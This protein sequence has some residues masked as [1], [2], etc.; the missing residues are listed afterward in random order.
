MEQLIAELV[1]R[2]PSLMAVVV[3]L[4][5]F[6]AIFKPIVTAYQAYVE[7]TPGKEDDEKFEEIKNSSAYK[8]I[9]WFVDYLFSIK[10]PKAKPKS[11]PDEA[12]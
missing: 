8:S 4:G 2:Y 10:L 5:I 3:I 9:S 11:K 6:R 7:A 12:A 1:M